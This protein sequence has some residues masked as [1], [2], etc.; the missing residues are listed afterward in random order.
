MD[1]TSL[2][3][4][5]EKEVAGL[6][7]SLEKLDA[8]AS[9]LAATVKLLQLLPREVRDELASLA[10][11]VRRLIEAED[12]EEAAKQAREACRVALANAIK[13]VLG[14]SVEI[15]ECP[16]PDAAAGLAK[17]A[18]ASTAL[19]ML[20]ASMVER[21]GVRGLEAATSILDHL[22]QVVEELYDVGASVA[23]LLG[24]KVEDVAAKLASLLNPPPDPVKAVESIREKLNMLKRTVARLSDEATEFEIVLKECSGLCEAV[25][26][27][28]E[29]A[30][31]DLRSLIDS[32]DSLVDVVKA[33]MRFYESIARLKSSALRLAERLGTTTS[34][35]EEAV[36]VLAS[37]NMLDDLEV[38]VLAELLKHGRLDLVETARRIS[39]ELGVPEHEIAVRVY[40]LCM[41]GFAACSVTQA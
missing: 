33:L 40:Q 5:V 28:Y 21:S 23:G 24:T 11:S 22:G 9:S 16:S 7:S 27:A 26:S 31:S 30:R 1:H 34:S 35:L 18:S 3:S 15:D 10:A 25:K 4:I 14:S 20:V 36:K 38:K 39:A 17:A 37:N 6:R 32:A 8:I 29:T 13:T 12:Y 41:K 19:R 2:A